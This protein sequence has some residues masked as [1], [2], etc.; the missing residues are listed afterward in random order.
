LDTIAAQV[1]RDAST[2]RL[3]AVQNQI[4]DPLAL[5]PGMQLRI[6]MD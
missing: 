5:R 1:Y 6:P 4:V 3:I 2:W